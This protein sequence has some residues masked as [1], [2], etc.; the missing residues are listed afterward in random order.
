[1]QQFFPVEEGNTYLVLKP[2]AGAEI[3]GD[4]LFPNSKILQLPPLFFPKVGPKG[5]G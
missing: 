3:F 5:G 1:M 4:I 2:A